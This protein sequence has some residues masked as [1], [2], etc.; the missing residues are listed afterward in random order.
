MGEMREPGLR[1]LGGNI[2]WTL[3]VQG[4]LNEAMG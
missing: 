2:S 3:L 4:T 1:S